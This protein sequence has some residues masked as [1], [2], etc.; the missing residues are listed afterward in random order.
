MDPGRAME[1]ETE[2]SRIDFNGGVSVELRRGGGVLG[3]T[4][5]G[6]VAER[7]LIRV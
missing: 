7:I 3:G 2:G 1:V 5:V 4:E 6:I